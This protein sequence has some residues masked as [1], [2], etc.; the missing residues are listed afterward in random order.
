ME[1]EAAG[2]SEDVTTTT[3]GEG[4][5]SHED[6]AAEYDQ[7]CQ[8]PDDVQSAD[9]HEAKAGEEPSNFQLE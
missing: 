1:S 4:E 8:H 9:D 7:E 5:E 3:E 6:E 2:M